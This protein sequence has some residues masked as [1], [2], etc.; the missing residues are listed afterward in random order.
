MN[1]TVARYS[2]TKDNKG[3]TLGLLYVNGKW[4]CYTLED[5]IR[6]DFG[7]PKVMGET[8]IPVGKYKVSLAA[9]GTLHETYAKRYPEFHKG[10]LMLNGVPQF[11]G[12]LIHCGVN[13]S[14]TEGCLIVG[15]SVNNNA[16]A[17]GELGLSH[18]QAY[19]R[20]YKKVIAALNAGEVVEVEVINTLLR[21][22]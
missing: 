12:I 21:M 1:I 17:Y 4:E 6:I 2:T 18:Y 13:E 7:E 10:M 19:P 9:W 16:I 22:V 20:L 11:E 3:S 15:D 5:E 14:N 8:A